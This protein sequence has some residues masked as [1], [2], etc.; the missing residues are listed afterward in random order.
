MWED[1]RLAVAERAE[2]PFYG[3][4]GGVVPTPHGILNEVKKYAH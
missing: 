4:M 2:T 1:V 3:E